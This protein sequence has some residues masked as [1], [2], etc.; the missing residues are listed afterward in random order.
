VKR[1]PGPGPGVSVILFARAA[2]EAL[3]RSLASLRE[4]DGIE[5]AEVL[6]ADGSGDPRMADMAGCFPGLRHLR[7]DPA[8]MPVL[9]GA[10]IRAAAGEV[11]AILDPGDVAEPGWLR[12]LRQ[13]LE[14]KIAAVGGCVTLDPAAGTVD[15]AAYLFEYGAFAPPLPG[16]PT[17]GDLPGNNVAYRREVLV[18]WCGDL[19]LRGFW[20]PFF[21]QRI[22]GRG[23]ILSLRPEMRVRHCTGY[24]GG[25]ALTRFY[26]F[27]RCFGGMRP[28]YV[29]PARRLAYRVLC[30]LIPFQLSLRHLLRAGRR[31]G[32]RRLLPSAGPMLVAI[33][34]AWGVGEC[35]G[36]W[37]GA[38]RSCHK[39][40]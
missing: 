10:A 28:M 12:G 27:G 25:Q 36:Y 30:P 32:T 1:M 24:T 39:V 16:G 5:E 34:V 37:L 21:H 29:S 2:D 38:G 19:L 20:K 8:P 26:H 7:L 31:K 14:E 15:R 33:C 17:A 40:V 11:V 35:V 6:L 13:S 4:Q 3:R 9:K 23:G 18:D 22:R